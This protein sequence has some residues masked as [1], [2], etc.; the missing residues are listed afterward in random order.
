[1]LY[2]IGL[3][4]QPNHLTLEAMEA[5]RG[6][7]VVFLENYTSR[8]AEGTKKELENN[9]QKTI[10]DLNRK[11]VEEEF[12]AVLEKALHEN[13]ALLVFGNPL[14]ATTHIQVLLDAKK[15]GVATNAIPGISIVD[16]LGKTGLDSYKFGR[17]S[18]IVFQEANYSP[19]SFFDI[20]ETNHQNGFHSLCLQDIHSEENRLMSVP[21]AIGI[22]EKIAK[23]KKADWFLDA[24]LVGLYGLGSKN[25][26]IVAGKPKKLQNS[27]Y[28]AWPQSLI[29]CG[30][31]NE[32]EKEALKELHGAEL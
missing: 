31:L 1:M 15:H 32:K 29:V 27:G 16:L 7:S 6:C 25:E 8:F 22:L 14:T 23:K 24:V 5:I 3:G 4:L 18:T 17:V 9:I 26:K 28:N 20:I 19:E 11:N 12:G 21:E 2:I 10:I 13:I 30:K